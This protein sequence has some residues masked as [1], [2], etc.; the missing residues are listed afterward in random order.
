MSNIHE[1]IV[2]E[3]ARLE[4]EL[5]AKVARKLAE[6]QLGLLW[7]DLVDERE[8]LEGDRTRAA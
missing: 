7:I 8:P 5:R 2:L 6:R 3:M 4:R 1:D